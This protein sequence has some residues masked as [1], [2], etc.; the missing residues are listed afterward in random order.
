MYRKVKI[1]GFRIELNEIE[2]ALGQQ[3]GIQAAAVAV[4]ANG[5]KRIAAYV[6][7]EPPAPSAQALRSG[8]LK[9]L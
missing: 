1:R 3:P 7:V 2:L 4:D 5:D 9:W 6:T 8:L